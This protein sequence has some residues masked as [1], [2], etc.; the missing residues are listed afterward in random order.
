MVKRSTPQE[1]ARARARARVPSLVSA[2]GAQAR[3][4]AAEPLGKQRPTA[5]RQ[6]ER[7]GE[8]ASARRAL[9]VAPRKHP[10]AA[11]EPHR[12]GC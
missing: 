5:A 1:R 6:L 7:D 3:A 11:H 10:P 2:S 9:G 12:A 8:A 4:D